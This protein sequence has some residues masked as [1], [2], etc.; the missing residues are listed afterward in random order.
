MLQKHSRGGGGSIGSSPSNLDTIHLI[1][2]M[3]GTYNE[4]PLYVLLHVT[5]WCIGGFHGNHSY[6][7]EVAVLDFEGFKFY[8][9]WNNNTAND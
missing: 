3:F 6:I 1:V 4:L 8:P 7:N 5:T 9:K 2:V